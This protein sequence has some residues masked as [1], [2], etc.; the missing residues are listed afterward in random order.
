M[1]PVVPSEFAMRFSV[2]LAYFAVSLSQ[3]QTQP[4]AECLPCHPAETKSHQ[5]SRM[6]HAMVPAATSAFAEHTTEIKLKESENGFEFTYQRIETGLAVR[7]QRGNE[8][9]QGTIEWVFGAGAQGQTPLV[10]GPN[11]MLESRVSYFPGLN[12]YGITVGQ[13]AGASPNAIAALGL[14]QSNRD[15]QA[16][17]GCHASAITPDLRPVVPGVQ[18][19]R[20]H[21][22]ASEHARTNGVS[23]V[24]N[25]GKLSAPEQVRFCGNCHRVRPPVDDKQLENIRFQPLRLMKSRCFASGKL[26]CTTCHPAHQ[27]AKRNDDAF[28]NEKCQMCHSASEP[29]GAPHRDG[30]QTGDCIGCHMPEVQL[31]PALRFTD[32]YIRVVA[33]KEST[34]AAQ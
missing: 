15:L 19:V 9:A 24:G 13:A 10:Q 1:R 34:V 21:S 14:R 4:G 2:I 31:H 33:G 8:T 11:G 22:G 26:A 5:R 20:C 27:D 6:A 30:R 12:Q 3:A 7:A 28:Y 29:Q 25:P 23:K 32:H 18:C 17:I 16:C